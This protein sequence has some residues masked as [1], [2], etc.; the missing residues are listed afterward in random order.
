MPLVSVNDTRGKNMLKKHFTKRS[1]KKMAKWEKEIKNLKAHEIII[2]DSL[3]EKDKEVKSAKVEEVKE[4]HETARK[5]LL[6]T[7]VDT[8]KKRN[9]FEFKTV[10]WY[11]DVTEDEEDEHVMVR[12]AKLLGPSVVGIVEESEEESVDS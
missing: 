1:K 11:G 2:L 6:N 8:V 7:L 4:L 3:K 9:Q 5:N 12:A 10:C